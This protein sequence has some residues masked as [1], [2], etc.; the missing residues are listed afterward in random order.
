MTPTDKTDLARQ[1]EFEYHSI[2]AANPSWDKTLREFLHSR[3]LSYKWLTMNGY[4]GPRRHASGTPPN[5]HL[6]LTDSEI[7]YCQR[8][9]GKSA[10]MHKL[11]RNVMRRE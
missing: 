7:D 5:T 1:L 8:H 4:P 10:V 2:V 6:V 11:L 9:G 3:G